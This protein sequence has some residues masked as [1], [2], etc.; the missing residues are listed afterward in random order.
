MM[1]TSSCLHSTKQ[2]TIEYSLCFKWH[3]FVDT[4]NSLWRYSLLPE[5][6]NLIWI[7]LIKKYVLFN[8]LSLSVTKKKH[9]SWKILKPVLV[10]D[11]PVMLSLVT[12]SVSTS[13]KTRPASFWLTP[14]FVSA[15]PT[16]GFTSDLSKNWFYSKEKTFKDSDSQSKY[17]RKYIR[18][19]T[20]N[21]TFELEIRLFPDYLSVQ[22]FELRY[23][24]ERII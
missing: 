7:I 10:V 19:K 16:C 4:R 1:Q 23:V 13:S 22:V 6:C 24:A 20:Q 12:S 11:L 14:M 18:S 3:T 5:T 21:L 8:S 15:S 9:D 17:N 2:M